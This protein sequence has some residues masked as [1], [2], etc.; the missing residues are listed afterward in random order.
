MCNLIN[1]YRLAT[2]IMISSFHN[3]VIKEVTEAC[4][5][6]RDFVVQ[7]LRNSDGGPDDYDIDES[8]TGVNV[9]YSQLSRQLV[10]RLRTVD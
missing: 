3:H 9:I 5:G 10:E 2:Q 6:K 4:E 1:K 8:I 7:S